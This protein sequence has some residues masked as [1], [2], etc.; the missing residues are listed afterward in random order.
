VKG[1]SVT[2]TFDSPPDEHYYGLG[3][4]PKRAGWTSGITRS[5]AGMTT[6]GDWGRGCLRAVYGIESRLRLGMV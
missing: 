2:A 1:Y 4:Q 5:D 3:Q 6:G